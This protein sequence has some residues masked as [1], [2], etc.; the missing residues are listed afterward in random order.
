MLAPSTKEVQIDMGDFSEKV[1]AKELHGRVAHNLYIQD[2]KGSSGKGIRAKP[3]LSRS[4]RSI[5]QF[6]QSAFLPQGYPDSVSDDY[7][8]YQKWDTI[9][10]FCSYVTGT[11]ATQAVLKGLGVGDQ[12]ATAAGATVT[13][14]LRDGAGMVGRVIFAW[15][16]GT[17][18]D[19]NAKQWRLVADILNDTAMLLEL[20]SP[21]FPMY[22]LFIACLASLARSIVGV[23]GG[24]TRASITMHQARSGNMADV[25]AKDGSQETLVS[26]VGLIVGTIITPMINNNQMIIWT[27]FLTFTCCHLIANYMAVAVVR[28]DRL[29]FA[30]FHVAAQDFL[31]C[32]SIPGI[33]STNSREPLLMLLLPGGVHLQL[34]AQFNSVIESANDLD[35]FTFDRDE[36]YLMRLNLTSGRSVHRTGVISV[37][38]HPDVTA[39]DLMRLTLHA[40]IIQ[41]C[42]QVRKLDVAAPCQR[43]MTM[44]IDF[45]FNDNGSR[46]N[47]ARLLSK[48]DCQQVVNMSYRCAQRLFPEFQ[49]GLLAKGWLIDAVQF[50]VDEWRSMWDK[51]GIDVDPNKKL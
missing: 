5:G 30:R 28:M 4:S 21:F 11:L 2:G 8:D 38:L 33:T 7:L 14:L 19:C 37:V 17:D 42:L 3:L 39:D 12:T 40:E 32:G 15:I 6:L 43:E 34:G 35:G 18:L 27:L 1:L 36:K 29:N 24:A 48:A 49:A 45:I 10:A 47:D 51:Q 23:A 20:I 50:N 26:L 44:L 46:S 31:T 25:A 13:W 16:Q 41:L 9:Q 22:F